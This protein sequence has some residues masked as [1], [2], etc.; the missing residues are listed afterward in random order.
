MK[1]SSGLDALVRASR[2]VNIPPPDARERNRR[3]LAE[4][5]AAGVGAAAVAS[6][7]VRGAAAAITGGAAPAAGAGGSTA[8][9]GGLA[10]WAIVSL[11]IAAGGTGVGVYV[12]RARTLVR[13]GDTPMPLVKMEDTSTP[14]APVEPFHDEPAGSPTSPA[15]TEPSPPT[16]RASDPASPG[17]PSRAHQDPSALDARAFEHELQLLRSARRALDAGSPAQALVLLDRYAAEFPRGALRAESQATRILALCAAGRVA[18]AQ[19]ARSQFLE[20]HP[21]SPLA[22]GVR[23]SCARGR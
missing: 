9:A 21:G 2:T 20:Q 14:R 10:K 1:R 15:S 6:S 22:E 7:Y 12:A 3:R 8:L 17:G 18:H 16:S 5:I 4:R 23:T 13:M 11:L 19:Q